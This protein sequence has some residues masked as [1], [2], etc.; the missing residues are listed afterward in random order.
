MVGIL[1]SLL[2]TALGSSAGSP[3]EIADPAP[4]GTSAGRTV[5][6]Q[7]GCLACHTFGAVGND[8]PGPD[9]TT[10]GARLSRREIERS[11]RVGP[12]IMP[13]YA[14][15]KESDPQEFR[16]LIVYLAALGGR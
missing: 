6:S 12:G 4:E 9:L 10:I 14:G 15:L 2:L 3:T 16:D 1:V 8:G 11:V 7:S 5:A 13:S